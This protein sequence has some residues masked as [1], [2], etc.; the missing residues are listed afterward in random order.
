MRTSMGMLLAGALACTGEVKDVDDFDE[1][2]HCTDYIDA[3]NA[4]YAEV[5]DTALRVSEQDYRLCDSPSV[6]EVTVEEWR[7]YTE[8][9]TSG[10]CD[11]TDAIRALADR[12]AECERAADRPRRAAAR[13]VGPKTPTRRE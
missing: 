6:A 5:E 4:C 13:S 8:A 9:Y 7:C 10:S 2:A 12:L 11:S 1:A 3:V